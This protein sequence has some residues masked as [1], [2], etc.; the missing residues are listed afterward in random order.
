MKRILFLSFFVVGVLIASEP[1]AAGSASGV[2]APVC[3]ICMQPVDLTLS[4]DNSEA[5]VTTTALFRCNHPEL[6]HKSCLAG[7]A[8]CPLCRNPLI[9]QPA[10][11]HQPAVAPVAPMPVEPLIPLHM[12]NINQIISHNHADLQESDVLALSFVNIITIDGVV[13]V[14]INERWPNLRKLNLSNNQLADLP[15]EIVHL[16]QL[17]ELNLSNN[18][19]EVLPPEIGQLQQLRELNLANN[20]LLAALPPEIRLL[21]NLYRLNLS[22]NSLLAAAVLPE[23]GQL[24]NLRDLNLCHTQLADLPPEIRLL[25]NLRDLNL[26]HNQLAGLPPEI[27]LLT[28]LQRLDL[29]HNPLLAALPPEIRLLTNLYRLNLSHTPLVQSANWPDIRAQLQHEIPQLTIFD[30]Y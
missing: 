7:L 26:S 2:E 3:P 4:A 23:I 21:T 15:P 20:P 1:G 5:A 17:Q 8:R 29:S 10:P 12:T 18:R 30:H 13:F 19:L 24:R 6:F 25:T 27:R 16:Q 11:I 14:Q 28:N 22:S 9:A